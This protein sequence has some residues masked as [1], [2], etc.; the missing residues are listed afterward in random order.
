[1]KTLAAAPYVRGGG[2]GTSASGF[3]VMPPPEHKP[4]EYG[5]PMSIQFTIIQDAFIPKETL[6][7]VVSNSCLM[8]TSVCLFWC[9][10]LGTSSVGCPP[11]KSLHLHLFTHLN[12]FSPY[13]LS[14]FCCTSQGNYLFSLLQNCLVSPFIPPCLHRIDSTYVYFCNLPFLL[15]S[16]LLWGKTSLLV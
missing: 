14:S 5:R 7:H 4:Q 16:L 9:L 3:W 1:M 13:L 8:P 2:Q 10:F 11:Q 15:F 12:F 6:Y